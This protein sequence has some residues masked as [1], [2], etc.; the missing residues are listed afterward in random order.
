MEW[1]ERCVE[2]IVDNVVDATGRARR[3]FLVIN[4]A[5]LIT[6][7]GLW[8]QQ[9][10]WS[11][12][13]EQDRL[14]TGVTRCNAGSSPDAARQAKCAEL[15][16]AFAAV[17]KLNWDDYNS[18][19]VPV[20]GVKVDTDDVPLL[21]SFGVFILVTWWWWGLRRQNHATRDALRLVGDESSDLDLIRYVR[22]R[23]SGAFV[24]LTPTKDDR[25]EWSASTEAQQD[26]ESHSAL[27]RAL[28]KSLRVP[29]PAD[30]ARPSLGSGVVG[31]AMR[32]AVV[33]LQLLP[34]I[35]VLTA[36][37]MEIWECT[38]P[39]WVIEGLTFWG[40]ISQAGH[41]DAMIVRLAGA[42]VALVAVAVGLWG[43]V[44]W[45]RSTILL[46]AQIHLLV[47]RRERGSSDKLKAAA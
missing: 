39:S 34:L 30:A 42:C 16:T 15:T 2:A 14:R 40:D 29:S 41:A 9:L 21:G 18:I 31:I 10:S 19:S 43:C 7:L 6:L 1:G 8:N 45:T 17:T 24:L 5:C 22:H 13:T 35:T 38:Q 23:V 36:I 33:G 11:A 32:F 25:P 47:D 3:G 4:I 20:I 27:S 28:H 44:R 37:G 26:R 46:V 12:W